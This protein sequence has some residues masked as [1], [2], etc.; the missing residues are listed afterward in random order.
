MVARF[1]STSPRKRLSVYSQPFESLLDRIGIDFKKEGEVYE[2]GPDG[3]FR[4]YGG[5]FF[6]A[7]Q[8]VQSGERT[9]TD[10]PGFQYWFVDAKRLPRS[11]ADFG[12]S[13]AAVEFI[14]KLP[15]LLKD[16]APD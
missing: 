14:T 3:D 13:V 8:V 2:A 6:F 7:G 12:E 16:Q 11:D 10:R 15:W 1:A 5:W 9:V 4:T